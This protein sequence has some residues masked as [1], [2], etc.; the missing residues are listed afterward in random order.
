VRVESVAGEVLTC[1]VTDAYGQENAFPAS[2]TLA[3]WFLWEPWRNLNS[4]IPVPGYLCGLTV[5]RAGEVARSAP[6]GRE[7]GGQDICD[8]NWNRAHV[9][10]FIRCVG[11]RKRVRCHERYWHKRRDEERPQAI[12]DIV[13][14]D[15]RW[16]EHLSSGMAWDTTAYDADRPVNIDP[17]WRTPTVLA[18]AQQLNGG[19]DFSAMPILAD[20][21]Q[22]AGCDNDD[23]LAHCRCS[24]QHV[25]GCWVVDLV[26]GK[27]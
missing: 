20:A 5:E 7:L 1:R 18:L 2:R 19:R 27:E 4:G 15:P 24:G 26:L 8:E 9:A 13:A 3:L 11:V 17:R 6:I 21:L 10:R 22:D 14:T 23:I 25:R 12:Y 16:L